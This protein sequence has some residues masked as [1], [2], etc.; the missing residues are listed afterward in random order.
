[1][2][3][4]GRMIYVP[5]ELLSEAEIIRQAKDME[6]ATALREMAKYSQVGREAEQLLALRFDIFKRRKR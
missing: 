4:K 5:E 6:R 1:M 2:A 3:R